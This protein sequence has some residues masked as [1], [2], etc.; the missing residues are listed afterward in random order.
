MLSKLKALVTEEPLVMHKFILKD[1]NKRMGV[2]D[3]VS[4]LATANLLEQRVK[5]LHFEDPMTCANAV[6]N[7]KNMTKKGLLE[8][9]HT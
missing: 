7:I 1:I 2:I 5:N 6:Q 4:S 9:N 8:E 3:Q